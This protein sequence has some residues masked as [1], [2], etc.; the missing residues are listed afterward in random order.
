[1]SF[2]VVWPMRVDTSF[3]MVRSV[4][5]CRLSLSPVTTTQSQP[6][7]SHRREM[8]PIRSSASQPSSSY[9]GMR[10]ASSTSF[11]TGTCIRSSSGMGLRVAL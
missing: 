5:S 10:R 9:R 2:V 8:V 4:M 1:M 7:A 11:S 3:T 6:S